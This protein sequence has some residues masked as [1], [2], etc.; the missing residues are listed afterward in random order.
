MKPL[1]KI[2]QKELETLNRLVNKYF[3][4]EF[5][6]YFMHGLIT[7]ALCSASNTDIPKLFFGKIASVPM[8]QKLLNSFDSSEFFKLFQKFYDVIRDMLS[9]SKLFTPL[10][11]LTKLRQEGLK[12]EELSELEQRNLLSWYLGY[13]YSYGTTWMHSKI[14][15]F[16]NNHPQNQ[17][18]GSL[19]TLLSVALSTQVDM[20]QELLEKF[21]PKLEDERFTTIIALINRLHM[22]FKQSDVL[23]ELNDTNNKH[24]FC[25]YLSA[26]FGL[27]EMVTHYSLQVDKNNVTMH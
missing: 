24:L 12:K 6:I 5:D 1:Y 17:D 9:N 16:I 20:A 18:G 26:L 15:N 19:A 3:S 23:N 8:K 27:T 14:T 10:V 22:G 21:N 7:S 13:F 4:A 25:E 11:N 2:T